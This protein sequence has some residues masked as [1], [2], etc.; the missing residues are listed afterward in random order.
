MENNLTKAYAEVLLILSYMEQ[1]YI[2]MIFKKRE[3]VQQ[4]D[5]AK[6]ESIEINNVVQEIKQ[7]QKQKVEQK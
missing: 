5:E 2:D 3:N 6:E 4:K 1:K 7:I